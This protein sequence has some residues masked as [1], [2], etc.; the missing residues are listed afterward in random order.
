MIKI[1]P[2]YSLDVPKIFSKYD[3]DMPNI[4]LRFAQDMFKICPGY[5]PRYAQD[6]PRIV[7]SFNHQPKYRAY[8]DFWKTVGTTFQ[9]ILIS[10]CGD[11]VIKE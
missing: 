2:R 6:K 8:A 5:N 11:K 4:C 9:C 7:T 3:Q 1:Y 10:N